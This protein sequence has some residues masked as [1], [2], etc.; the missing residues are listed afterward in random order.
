MHGPKF[1]L[2]KRKALDPQSIECIFVGYPNG[3]KGHKLIDLYSDRLIIERSFQ[4]KESVSYVPQQQHANTF[5]LRPIRDDEHAHAKY[6]SDE[7]SD[8][9]DSDDPNTD[10]VHSGVDSMHLDVDV[11]LEKRPK[12][13]HTTLQ[14]VGDLVGDPTDTRKTRYEFEGPP[15]ALTAT[16]PFPPKNLFL[17]ESSDPHSYDEAAENPFWESTMEKDYKSLLE[18][19]TW[20]LVSLPSGRKIVR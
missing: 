6:S 18:N 11:E 7:S 12:W 15:L 1:P 20:D 8:S 3:V 14:D 10:S 9:E 19:H 16:E 5:V 17:V 4:F 2:K 13:A